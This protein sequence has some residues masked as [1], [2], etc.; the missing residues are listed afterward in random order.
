MYYNILTVR[1]F[2]VDINGM[3]VKEIDPMD[4]WMD[5]SMGGWMPWINGL[6]DGCD[7]SDTSMCVV[8][9]YTVAGICIA[10]PMEVSYKGERRFTFI[11]KCIDV[12]PFIII[13]SNKSIVMYSSQIKYNKRYIP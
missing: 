4:G 3:V 7:R 5:G 13:M 10:S 1:N 8:L 2:L 12:I 9:D 11:I 6:I